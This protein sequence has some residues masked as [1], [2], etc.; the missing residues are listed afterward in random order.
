LSRHQSEVGGDLA[1]IF[2]PMRIVDAGNENL[3]GAWADSG[4]CLDACDTR[5]ILTDRFKFLD[6]TVKQFAERIQK[7]E[8]NI[9]LALP[10]FIGATLCQ[11]FTERVDAGS[12]GVPGF[13]ASVDGDPMIDE[14]GADGV[15]ELVDALVK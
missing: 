3:C 12:A 2:E 11:R 15:L 1:T 7:R 4:D 9:E 5:I 14:P 6:D 13:L 10:E 8:F